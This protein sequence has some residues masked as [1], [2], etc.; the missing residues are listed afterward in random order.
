MPAALSTFGT[1][2]EFGKV[3]EYSFGSLPITLLTMIIN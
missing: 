1:L 2:A 3:A